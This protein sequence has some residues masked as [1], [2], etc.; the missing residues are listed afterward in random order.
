MFASQF[1]VEAEILMSTL[2]FAAP[3]ITTPGV[4]KLA[5]PANRCRQMTVPAGDSMVSRAAA[6]PDPEIAVIMARVAPG[7]RVWVA[8]RPAFVPTP[9]RLH[10]PNP[11]AL[12]VS[13]MGMWSVAPLGSHAEQGAKTG[14]D[15]S[16][17]GDE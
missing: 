11:K 12:G 4:E 1:A 16:A 2:W 10:A 9:V 3:G 8:V 13:R 14:Y 17:T 5:A 7:A 6:S 15:G